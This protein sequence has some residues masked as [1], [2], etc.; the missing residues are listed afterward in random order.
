MIDCS[1]LFSPFGLAFLISA[2]KRDTIAAD[3]GAIA[4]TAPM[5]RN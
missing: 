1:I 4:R 2:A 5:F 3:V